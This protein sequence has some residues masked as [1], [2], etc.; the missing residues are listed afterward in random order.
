MAERILLT[1]GT[2]FF[3]RRI[4]AALREHGFDL[5]TPGRPD[6]DLMDPALT[7]RTFERLRPE[8]C[9]PLCGLLRWAGD[10]HGRARADLPQQR[11]DGG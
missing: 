4:A 8:D 11:H 2:G 5:T 9:R 6:F 7:L 1:G 10:L 3:G